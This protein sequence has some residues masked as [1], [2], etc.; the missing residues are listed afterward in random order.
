MLEEISIRNLAVIESVRVRFTEGFQ[1]LTGETGAGKS[2][3]ID[4]L[5][6]LI[7]G[8]AS[9]EWI[10]HGTDRAEIEGLFALD[11]D[12]PVWQVLQELGLRRTAGNRF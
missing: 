3:I 8:R 11:A 12:H 9:T 10:R 2:M 4:A 5:S 7:G 1:V 6:L